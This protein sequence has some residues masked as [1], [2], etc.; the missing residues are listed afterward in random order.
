LDEADQLVDGSFEEEL[1][2]IFQCLPENR[3]NL[4][5]SATMTSNLQKLCEAYQDKL[6]AFKAH[7]EVMKYDLKTF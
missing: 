1:K 3:Q 2:Y 7:E 5:F 6:Y 4:F